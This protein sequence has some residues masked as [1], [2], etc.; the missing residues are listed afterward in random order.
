M[1]DQ[2]HLYEFEESKQSKRIIDSDSPE[3]TKLFERLEIPEEIRHVF[4]D[5][6]IV[7]VKHVIVSINWYHRQLEIETQRKKRWFWATVV[8]AL[9]IPIV[10]AT[11]ELKLEGGLAFALVAAMISGAG[12]AH[13]MIAQFLEHRNVSA[14][15]SEAAAEL[16]DVLYSFEDKWAGHLSTLYEMN[17]AAHELQADFESSV[18]RASRILTDEKLKYYS[19]TTPPAIGLN[20]TPPRQLDESRKGFM[21]D[22]LSS[23]GARFTFSF[24]YS[25]EEREEVIASH[26]RICSHFPNCDY[27]DRDEK[28]TLQQAY[29]GKIHHHKI[30]GSNLGEAQPH[31]VT[32]GLNMDRLL[33]LGSRELDQTLIHEMMHCAGY[34]HPK[35]TLLDKPGDNGNYYGS[36][37]LKAELCIAGIQSDV[38]E[39]DKANVTSC[40]S[41]QGVYCNVIES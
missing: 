12:M 4:L 41:E 39:V 31:G 15:F 36:T 28:D 34:E 30:S 6:F 27:L 14:V 38:A 20:V 29:F 9:L 33:A 25:T 24:Q 5:E 7:F 32:V 18:K 13:R 8:L 16:K 17:L 37:P 23:I 2:V 1:I 3:L 35:K 11:I 40:S 26:Q 19:A 22:S 10:V 21:L